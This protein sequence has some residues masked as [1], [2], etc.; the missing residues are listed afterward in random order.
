LSA[1]NADTVDPTMSAHVIGTL[2]LTRQNGNDISR[3]S[4]C[5]VYKYLQMGMTT[6]S[7]R[8]EE[9]WLHSMPEC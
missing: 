9:C 8:R 4:L 3:A 1:N 7:R 6:T 2:Q 5:H